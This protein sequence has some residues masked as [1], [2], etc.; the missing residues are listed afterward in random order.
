MASVL[1]EPVASAIVVLDETGGATLSEIA[2]ATGKSVSTVQRAIHT[3]RQSGAVQRDGS[4]GRLRFAP[5][6]PRQALRELADWRLGLSPEL[7]PM[8]DSGRPVAATLTTKTRDIDSL[9][10]RR[11]LNEAVRSIVSEY[12]PSRVILF[13]SR[14]RGDAGPDSDVDLLVVFD[15]VPDRRERAVGIAKL[16]RGAPFPKDIL[17]ASASDVARPTAGT[18]IAEAMHEGRV[19]Y[20]R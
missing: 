1:T 9:S 11:A 15:E 18:A 3:L 12:H 19:I 4:G 13:G 5:G 20:E 16:L 2:R 6:A 14:A 10:F 7:A 8:R 17:V